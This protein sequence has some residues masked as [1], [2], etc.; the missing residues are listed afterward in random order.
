MSR[1]SWPV[2]GARSIGPTELHTLFQPRDQN[3]LVDVVAE[4]ELLNWERWP[5]DPAAESVRNRLSAGGGS[6]LRTRLGNA[7]AKSG[8]WHSN[9]KWTFSPGG[10]LI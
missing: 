7:A 8:L 3:D 10:Q 1:T 6:L 5:L 4:Q 2:C 9:G